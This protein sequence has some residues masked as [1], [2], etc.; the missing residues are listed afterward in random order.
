MVMAIDG[1]FFRCGADQEGN[2][3]IRFGLADL[4]DIK[5]I[6]NS[7][8]REGMRLARGRNRDQKGLPGRPGIFGLRTVED[9]LDGG[10]EDSAVA[11]AMEGQPERG[12]LSLKVIWYTGMAVFG[13]SKRGSPVCCAELAATMH[14]KANEAAR[15]A[16]T[17]VI[18]YLRS[19]VLLGGVAKDRGADTT[20]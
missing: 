12:S 11:G 16:R 14:A 7:V 17:R 13:P 8:Q 6:T 1:T 9:G 5:E 20:S 2:S 4:M 19:S 15:A 3:G 10:Y 18:A